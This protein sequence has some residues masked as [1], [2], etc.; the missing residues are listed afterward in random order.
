MM[1]SKEVRKEKIWNYVLGGGIIFVFVSFAVVF[2]MLIWGMSLLSDSL[3]KKWDNDAEINFIDQA[4]QQGYSDS[5]MLDPHCF[6]SPQHGWFGSCQ[7]YV[8]EWAKKHNLPLLEG[9][10]DK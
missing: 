2:G 1:S 3:N 8:N 6:G 7:K 5:E 4:H 9:N 10:L